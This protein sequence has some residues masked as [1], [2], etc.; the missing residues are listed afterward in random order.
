MK[1]FI[2]ELYPH[3]NTFENIKDNIYHGGLALCLTVIKILKKIPRK[4]LMN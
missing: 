4:K 2:I 1:I 3:S